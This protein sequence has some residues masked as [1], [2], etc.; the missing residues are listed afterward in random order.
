MMMTAFYG[1]S[2]TFYRVV[3]NEKIWI[4]WNLF[5][6][7]ISAARSSSDECGVERDFRREIRNAIHSCPSVDY[8]SI[9]INMLEQYEQILAVKA[10]EK[11]AQLAINEKHAREKEERK[12]KD[13]QI[14]QNILKTS[15]PEELEAI[16]LVKLDGQKLA[17]NC[18]DD[19]AV[20]DGNEN[21]DNSSTDS[22]ASVNNAKHSRSKKKRLL[23]GNNNFKNNNELK[24]TIKIMNDT[25][26]SITTKTT[27]TT[28]IKKK[29]EKPKKHKNFKTNANDFIEDETKSVTEKSLSNNNKRS[30]SDI[31]G[32]SDSLYNN[33]EDNNNS[34]KKIPKIKH[35]NNNYNHNNY[36]NTSTSANT[37]TNTNSNEKNTRVLNDKTLNFITAGAAGNIFFPVVFSFLIVFDIFPAVYYYIFYRWQHHITHQKYGKKKH[38]YY[39][40]IFS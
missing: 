36:N 34:S 20:E 3:N 32:S 19:G 5:P 24:K 11:A 40:H 17:G 31:G 13:F 8:E 12:Q 1:Y 9:H 38:Y 28:I 10:S 7:L 6:E 16:R 25:N 33:D 35:N 29:N 14:K 30:S 15:D 27:T 4:I 2:L 22:E 37:N 26:S 23:G 21:T 39:K 18:F